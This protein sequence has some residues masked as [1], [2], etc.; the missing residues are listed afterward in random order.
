MLERAKEELEILEWQYPN[1]FNSLKMDLRTLISDFEYSQTLLPL[2]SNG[3]TSTC[4]FAASQ[5]SST[6]RK[7]KKCPSA[8]E[9][10][11]NANDEALRSKSDVCIKRKCKTDA[12]LERAHKCLNKIQRF[13]TS[14][15]F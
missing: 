7:R 3:S 9:E 15:Y 4:S 14:L 8:R 13:K 11:G 12:V 10:D 1:K 2:P 5:E 6:R